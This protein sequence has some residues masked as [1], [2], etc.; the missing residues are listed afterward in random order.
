MN[1]TTLTSA[2]PYISAGIVTATENCRGDEEKWLVILNK[3]FKDTCHFDH[4]YTSPTTLLHSLVTWAG[5]LREEVFIFVQEQAVFFSPF[6]SFFLFCFEAYSFSG[7]WSSAWTA[8]LAE[9]LHRHPVHLQDLIPHSLHSKSHIHGTP[10]PVVLH[11]CTSVHAPRKPRT[12]LN[13]L[14]KHWSTLQYT[15]SGFDESCRLT[16]QP[17]GTSFCPG[18][19]AEKYGSN[20]FQIFRFRQIAIFFF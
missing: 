16:M 15:C 8:G 13:L 18:N 12:S 3:S 2:G 6:S 1:R 4:T 19:F 11:P 14:C 17:S 7:C 5:S 9:I 20:C 10:Q